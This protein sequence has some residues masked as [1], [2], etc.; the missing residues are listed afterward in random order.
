MYSPFPVCSPRSG[1]TLQAPLCTRPRPVPRRCDSHQ[2]DYKGRKK[3]APKREQKKSTAHR[4][5]RSCGRH[6][7]GLGRNSG[8]PQRPAPQPPPPASNHSRISPL[9]PRSL[10]PPRPAPPSHIHGGEEVQYRLPAPA[11]EDCVEYETSSFW[12]WLPRPLNRLI[13]SDANFRMVGL[14][15]AKRGAY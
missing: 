3:R 6:E 7:V 9:T 10:H 14:A 11:R 12:G 5:G 15:V 2:G 1:G 4:L 13:R 8:V